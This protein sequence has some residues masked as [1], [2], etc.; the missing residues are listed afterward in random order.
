MPGQAF[1]VQLCTTLSEPGA[2][3]LGSFK[4]GFRKLVYCL[5]QEARGSR[6]KGVAGTRFLVGRKE[7][8]KQGGQEQVLEHLA[9]PNFFLVAPQLMPL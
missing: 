6:E 4:M 2:Q 5:L 8:K 1:M 9:M 7:G 3:R